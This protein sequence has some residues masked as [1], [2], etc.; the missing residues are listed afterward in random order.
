[1]WVLILALLI[2]SCLTLQSSLCPLSFSFL[3]CKVSIKNVDLTV[4]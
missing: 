4:W 3:S 1:M 2:S